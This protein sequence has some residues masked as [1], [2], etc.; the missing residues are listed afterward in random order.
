MRLKG[1]WIWRRLRKIDPVLLG[2]TLALSLI[3]IITIW[4]AVDNFGFSKLRMQIAMTVAG[5]ILTVVI[6]NLDISFIIDRFWIGMALISVV[7]LGLTLVFGS[8]GASMDTSNKSWLTIPIVNIMIQPSEF[9]KFLLI[10]SFAKHISLVQDRINYPLPLLG[11]ALHA[12]A[13]VGMILLSGDLGVALLFV[14]FILFM[15]YGAGLSLWYDVGLAAAA[16]VAFPFLYNYVLKDYQVKRIYYGF[17]P[18][19]DPVRWGW[20]AL[21]GRKTIEHGGFLGIGFS[22]PGYYETLPASHTD[23]IFCTICE[24]FGFLM[25]ALT[26]LVLLVLVLRILKIARQKSNYYGGLICLGVAAVIIAQTAE[27]I[28]MCFALVPVVGITLPFLSCGGSSL[29]ATFMLV[30]LVHSVGARED[31][32]YLDKKTK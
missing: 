6:A 30:G 27:N 10:C 13:I 19:E 11:L 21:Y 2:C 28:A 12:G 18:E 15:L 24:K 29:L 26:I 3:S 4:G 20:Q 16:V 1:N 9:V 8:S 32:Y 25:G 22:T 7:F 23:F 31:R 17:H 14:A 5:C